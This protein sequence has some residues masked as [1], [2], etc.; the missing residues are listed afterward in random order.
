MTSRGVTLGLCGLLVLSFADRSRGQITPPAVESPF[1]V[2]AFATGLNFPKSMQALS[3]G[4]LLVA[5]SRP[6]GVGGSF[7]DSTG[8]L[9]RLVDLDGDGHADGAPQVV[10]SGLPGGLTAMRSLGDLT[11]VTSSEGIH[12]LRAGASPGDAFTSLGQ[13]GLSF[14]AGWWHGSSGM[15]VREAAGQPGVTELYFNIG[16][17]FNDTPSTDTV[18]A[19]GLISGTLLGESI[20]RVTVDDRGATPSV[21][22]L[23][24]VATGLRNA[25]GIAFHPT[26]GNLY[27]SENGMDDPILSVEPKSPDELNVLAS[28]QIG[29]AIEDYGFAHDFIR[30][31]TGERVGSGAI[32]PLAAFQPIPDPFTGSES[33]GAVEIA[34]APES[35][36]PYLGDGVFVGFHGEFNLGGLA[37]E[38]NPLVLVDLATGSYRHFIGND[39]PYIGHIAGL[40]ATSDALY[41]ADLTSSGNMLGSQ[42]DG[43][44]YRITAAAVPEPGTWVLLATGLVVLGIRR[45]AR[46]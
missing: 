40:L 39:E 15:A 29:G 20:Y 13:I 31:R 45:A 5:T 38:E 10:Y 41:L 12:V 28:G 35:F 14:P 22:G 18:T 36:R 24:Q 11:F 44:I 4:S 3:D 26:T 6:N 37:N 42:S 7:F 25:S 16:S 46:R 30:Y 43:V 17:Q 19:S 21:S 1:V 2:T 27:F 23:E 34:F 33:E 8:E 32:Q 9:I